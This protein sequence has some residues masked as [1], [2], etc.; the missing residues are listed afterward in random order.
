[1]AKKE[2]VRRARSERVY[3]REAQLEAL[4][5]TFSRGVPFN[6]TAKEVILSGGGGK[7]FDVL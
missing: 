7:Q 3:E 5:N 2:S 6:F 4:L 1:M